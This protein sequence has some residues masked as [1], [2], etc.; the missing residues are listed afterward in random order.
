MERDAGQLEAAIRGNLQPGEGVV[1]QQC[2]VCR[3]GEVLLRR[4]EFEEQP[5]A[6][7]GELVGGEEVLHDDEAL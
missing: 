1:D 4:G 7:D 5:G 3:M 2:M 6:C